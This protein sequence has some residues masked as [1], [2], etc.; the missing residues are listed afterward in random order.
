MR[1]RWPCSLRRHRHPRGRVKDERIMPALERSRR[2]QR[3][4]WCSPVSR[5]D[6]GAPGPVA[7]PTRQA[8]QGSLSAC[9]T[10][11]NRSPC[12]A[13]PILARRTA[14]DEIGTYL[15]FPP[16]LP[17]ARATWQ[18]GSRAPPRAL[19]SAPGSRRFPRA[20]AVLF[21]NGALD[22]DAEILV[23]RPP[24]NPYALA[25]FSPF[26]RSKRNSGRS[27]PIRARLGRWRRRRT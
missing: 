26:V 18:A 27:S 21:P 12:P 13:S 19:R 23:R 22:V 20:G 8:G 1:G 17:G 16:A 11:S 7:R 10:K 25:I 24:R 6:H 4:R 2:S 14:T 9:L 15:R 5:P 3:R